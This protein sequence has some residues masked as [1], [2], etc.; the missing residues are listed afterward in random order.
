MGDEKLTGVRIGLRSDGIAIDGIESIGDGAVEIAFHK[1]AKRAW[2]VT[3]EDTSEEMIV[4]AMRRQF[5]PTTKWM[6]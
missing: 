4:E 2:M 1:D 5:S 6:T 3:S